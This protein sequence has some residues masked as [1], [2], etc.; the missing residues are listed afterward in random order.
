MS[1]KTVQSMFDGEFPG[2]DLPDDFFSLEFDPLVREDPLMY[3][4][5]DRV[6]IENSKKVENRV[7]SSNLVFMD[8][9]KKEMNVGPRDHTQ[10]YYVPDEDWRGVDLVFSY[11][12]RFEKGSMDDFPDIPIAECGIPSNQYEGSKDFYRLER[13]FADL[14]FVLYEPTIG[15]RLDLK[16]VYPY[17]VSPNENVA[18]NGDE[19]TYDNY[20]KKPETIFFSPYNNVDLPQVVSMAFNPFHPMSIPLIHDMEWV[21]DRVVR[22]TYMYKN[23]FLTPFEYSLDDKRFRVLSEQWCTM[24]QNREKS[25]LYECYDLVSSTDF[26]SRLPFM[27]G[28]VVEPF[29]IEPMTY[30]GPPV[31][32]P[33]AHLGPWGKVSRFVSGKRYGAFYSRTTFDVPEEITRY[34]EVSTEVVVQDEYSMV[35]NG[36][37]IPLTNYIPNVDNYFVRRIQKKNDNKIRVFKKDSE[38][39]FSFYFVPFPLLSFPRNKFGTIIAHLKSMSL[40]GAIEAYQ[41]RREKFHEFLPMWAPRYVDFRDYVVDE[42]DYSQIVRP[43]KVYHVSDPAMEPEI[44]YDL[45]YDAIVSKDTASYPSEE[46]NSDR[47]LPVIN[48]SKVNKSRNVNKTGR[49]GKVK[50]KRK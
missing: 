17:V 32:Y 45:D 34:S 4:L 44:I 27:E 9:G 47:V 40:I 48:T 6:D 39:S 14:G 1:I 3:V 49:G 37:Y 10:P 31:V 25:F 13:I 50:K 12:E 41:N 21:D 33:Y 28:R 29:I 22:G 16:G 38:G 19:Y 20:P 26:A 24:I 2:E 43:M 42:I 30:S 15:C 46:P 7:F 35:H 36:E 5:R 18:T 23:K 11:I 8:F